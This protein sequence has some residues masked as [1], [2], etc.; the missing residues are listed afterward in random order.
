MHSLR[1]ATPRCWAITCLM[2]MIYTNKLAGDRH[3][4]STAPQPRLPLLLGHGP[5]P[6][7]QTRQHTRASTRVLPTRRASAPRSSC[8]SWAHTGAR[9]ARGTDP[10]FAPSA[11]T[12][13]GPVTARGPHKQAPPHGSNSRS[14][15]PPPRGAAAPHTDRPPAPLG[16]GGGHGGKER[17]GVTGHGHSH[18][19]GGSAA[20]D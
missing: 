1:I 13:R 9:V 12:T 14:L 16:E 8:H 5:P 18:G 3:S 4:P 6:H 10:H 17:E 19:G 7:R 11:P 15:L 2:H 20:T